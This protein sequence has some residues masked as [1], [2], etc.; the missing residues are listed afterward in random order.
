MQNQGPQDEVTGWPKTPWEAPRW[1]NP[2]WENPRWENPRWEN[3]RWENPRWENEGWENETISDS[4]VQNG[5]YRHV[6]AA[7][8][9]IGNTTSAYEVRV[10]VNGADARLRYQLIAY[11]L[12]TTAG[13]DLCEHSL[14]GNTQVLV[15][16]PN[17]D[18]SASNLN[19]PPPESV[20]NTTIHLHPGETV[21]TVLVAFDPTTRTFIDARLPLTNVLFAARPQAVNTVDADAGVRVPPLVF[22]DSPFLTFTTQPTDTSVNTPIGQSTEQPV[23]VEAQN[24]QG[25]VIPN[26]PIT[27]AIGN[28]PSGGT[29]SGT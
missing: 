28:N 7:Y 23:R 14:V 25:A 17:Y 6:R 24:G 27:I 3:P 21:Y 26:L 19:S 8:T 18:P 5:S 12:Y 13:E 1:E 4:D 2:R 29:V 10:V 20:Q 9:N 15:N 11:K 16:I 22:N